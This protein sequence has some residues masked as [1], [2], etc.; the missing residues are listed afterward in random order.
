MIT[1]IKPLFEAMSPQQL[2]Q[3]VREICDELEYRQKF[4]SLTHIADNVLS[5]ATDDQ[6]K[7]EYWQRTRNDREF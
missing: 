2:E 5:H 1:D 4:A 3:A 7:S 6:L